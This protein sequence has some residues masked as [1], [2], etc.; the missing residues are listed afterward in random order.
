MA[1]RTA[2]PTAA[3]PAARP[4]TRPTADAARLLTSQ[5]GLPLVER[6]GLL[7]LSHAKAPAPGEGH[8]DAAERVQVVDALLTAIGGAYCHLLQKR[9]GYAIDPVQA[10][11][12]LRTQAADLSEAEFHLVLTGIVTGLRDAHTSY[13][14][15]KSLAGAVA[16]LPFLVEQYGPTEAP[17]FLVTKVSS[18][19]LVKDARF[20]P[21]VRLE[22]W[23]GI[24]FER[25]VALHADRETG[26]RPD[27][28][29]ARALESLTFRSL[30]Y[31]P[32]P[33]ELWVDIGFRERAGG[34]RREV[35]IPWSIVKPGQAASGVAPGAR[36]ALRLAV[37]PA[38]EHVR[39]AKKLMF[40]GRQWLAENE[41]HELARD[42]GWL[43]TRFPD[44]LSA[45]RVPTTTPLGDIGYLRIWTFDVED[46]EAFVNEVARL[47][48]QLPDTGLV[49]DLRA[50]PGGLIWAAERLLQLFTPN[51]VSPTRFALVATPL[52]RAMARSAF[53][54]MELEPWIPSL[55]SALSTGEA[56]SQALP[57]TD[58][59]W[60]DDVGQ[61]YGGPVVCVADANTYSSGDLFCAGF[62]DNEVGALVCVGQAT[63]AGGANVWTDQDLAD[64]LEGTDFALPPLPQGVGFTLAFRRAVRARDAAGVPIEDL[65]VAG[66]PYAMTERDVMD[67]NADLLAWCARLLAGAPRT[68]LQVVLGKADVRITTAGL[69]ELELHVDGRPAGAAMPI[70]DGERV[71]PRPAQG[72]VL[73]VVG[74]QGGTVFQR[75]RL[76]L[77]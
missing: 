37:S 50:N 2:T 53:N 26:G 77:G 11:Q 6:A 63:G 28:R 15:P 48:E 20:R 69:D 44:A 68:R 46:H 43:E 38:A 12:L 21:G 5:A 31:G 62:V 19:K 42:P 54:R 35:R 8:L 7:A 4:S 27:A 73:E 58:P 13:S 41:R 39:R 52:T 3:R 9:A 57:L 40:S 30:Q 66:I 47:V 65:G 71:L 17:H 49:I 10:L 70:A 23:N 45:R 1:T 59:A 75:R 72:K 36:A 29:L 22:T 74:R 67:G 55:E 16:R 61:R 14:G 56:Y 51:P 32:P 60:C 25:A 34:A 64:A 76:P 33:D 24:P 18:P